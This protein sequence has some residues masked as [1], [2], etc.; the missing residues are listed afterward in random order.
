[1]ASFHIAAMM[2]ADLGHQE[3]YVS[4]LFLVNATLLHRQELSNLNLSKMSLTFHIT[5]VIQLIPCPT[6]AKI[7]PPQLSRVAL[8]TRRFMRDAVL[9]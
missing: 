6:G 5:T 2:F 8:E 4:Y 3:A 9:I 7:V 1:M